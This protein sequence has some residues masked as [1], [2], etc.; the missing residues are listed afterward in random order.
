MIVNYPEVAVKEML[1]YVLNNYAREY[2]DT[3]KCQRCRDDTMAIALNNL[4]VKYVVQN[5]KGQIFTKVIFEQIGGKAQVVAA[6]VSA[7]QKVQ[8]NPRH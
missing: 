4:P 2:P 1:D 5:Q 7:I 6:L 8:Q 3:C